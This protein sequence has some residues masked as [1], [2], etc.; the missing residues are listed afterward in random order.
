MPDVDS[1]NHPSAR[2]L[3]PLAPFDVDLQVDPG[4]SSLSDDSEENAEPTASTLAFKF[5]TEGNGVYIETL[6]WKGIPVIID[7]G[8][9]KGNRCVVTPP[10]LSALP[11]KKWLCSGTLL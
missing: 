5:A 11:R 2:T 8:T 1:F 7:P 4:C 9:G 10:A 6:T 3:K